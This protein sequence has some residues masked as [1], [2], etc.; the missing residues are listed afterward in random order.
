MRFADRIDAGHRLAELLGDYAGRD[1]VIVLG[2]PRGGVPVAA[3]VARALDA[4]LDVLIVRKLGVPGHAEL[5]MGA[6]A[7]GG[8]RVMN[9]QVIEQAQ[10]TEA[11]IDA[12]TK[13]QQQELERRERAYRNGRSF[14]DLADRIVIVVDDG[15]ATGATMRAAVEALCQYAP[16]EVVVA[17]PVAPPHVEDAT[18][19]DADRVVVV[20]QPT[21]FLAVGHWY[22]DFTQTADAEVVQLLQPS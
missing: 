13:R 6:I 20:L 4:P 16:R 11:E 5:A 12:E 19:R 21:P 18:F 2:L 7:S 17:V 22:R 8:A 15:F 14:P 10:V 9:P 3:E 1:D